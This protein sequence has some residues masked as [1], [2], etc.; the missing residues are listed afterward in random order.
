MNEETS[1]CDDKDLEYAR[2]IY[3]ELI[4]ESREAILLM[5][6]LTQ[7]SGHPRSAEVLATTIKTA[8]DIT[9][10]LVELK[11]SKKKLQEKKEDQHQLTSN[12]T[13]NNLFLTTAD[14]QKQLQKTLVN[15]E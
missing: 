12:T 2:Q 3:L 14:L 6:E 9:D 13:N 10:R 7:E 11:I 15:A 1:D 8:S 5:K 4:E